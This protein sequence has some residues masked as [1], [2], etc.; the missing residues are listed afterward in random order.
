[1]S[2]FANF[3]L[4]NKSI[5]SLRLESSISWNTRNF[6]RLCFFIFQAWKVPS[7]NI[8]SFFK[9]QFHFLKYKKNSFWENIRIFLIL[10]LE[11]F[12]SQSIRKTFFWENI[13]HF[14]GWIFP[15]YYNY[16]SLGW[17]EV[18][19]APKSTT[20]A[21]GRE[22]WF[23]RNPL[24]EDTWILEEK[25]GFHAIKCLTLWRKGYEKMSGLQWIFS[26]IYKPPIHS[27]LN[28][29]ASPKIYQGQLLWNLLFMMVA[30]VTWCHHSG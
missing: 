15:F 4:R 25:E 27:A 8:R 29:L 18:Q 6:F 21:R 24:L 9:K 13:R 22:I 26:M 16:L 1:M 2:S 23:F 3:F 20:V 7:W 17:K 14:L 28:S 19:A 5:L 10:G 30:T 11:S 12:I